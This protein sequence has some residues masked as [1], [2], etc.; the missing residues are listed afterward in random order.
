MNGSINISNVSTSFPGQCHRDTRIPHVVF[1]LLYSV[2]FLAGFLLNSL[3]ALAFIRI[4]TTSSF[5]VY[6]KNILLSD[7]VMTLM[8]PF[9]I[10]T[11]SELGL[12]QLKAFVCRFSAVIFYE[13]MYISIVLLGLISLDRFLKIMRPFGRFW[14]QNVT[15][16]KIISGSVWL[17]FFCLSLPNMILSNREVTPHTV[18]KCASLKNQLGLKWH[19][20]VNYICQL[21][22]WTVLI[23]I[24]M[25][26][27]VIAKRIYSSYV[28]TQTTECKIRQRAKGKVFII[29]GVFFVCFA[30][31][32]FVRVPYTLSQT[33]KSM[34][35]STQNQLFIAKES[36]LLLAT[37][38][39]CMDPLIYIFLCRQFVEKALCTKLQRTV[40]TTQENVTIALDSGIST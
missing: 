26:Y 5:L 32:H 24:L 16:A 35:C 40:H 25:F 29:V 22:F 3:A 8:L 28:K 9:K 38:N 14:L 33:V 20:A 37:A 6:L 39:I 36:T 18:R 7:F 31:F 30:P 19:E 1:P 13:T 4:P 23:L 12:W 17:L 27:A 34:D 2:V 15:S 10:L 21:I 11:D